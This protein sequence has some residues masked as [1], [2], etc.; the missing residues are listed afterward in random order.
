MLCHSVLAILSGIPADNDGF[1]VVVKLAKMIWTG[2]ERMLLSIRATI[3]NVLNKNY[4]EAYKEGRVTLLMTSDTTLEL[5]TQI[6]EMVADMKN[7][8]KGIRGMAKRAQ[9]RASGVKVEIIG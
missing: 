8:W 6:P 9:L 7:D 5:E 2:G 1:K 4:R 3:D